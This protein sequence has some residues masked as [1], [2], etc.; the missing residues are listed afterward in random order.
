MNVVAGTQQGN[1]HHTT[2]EEGAMGSLGQSNALGIERPWQTGELRNN[3]VFAGLVALTQ[4]LSETDDL[5]HIL[6]IVTHTAVDLLHVSSGH[7]LLLQKDGF[8]TNR[9]SYHLPGAPVPASAKKLE[10]ISA[11]LIYHRLL[12]RDQPMVISRRSNSLRIAESQIFNLNAHMSLCMVALKVADDPLG[13]LLMFESREGYRSDPFS[14]WNL[15][16]SSMI[17]QQTANAIQRVQMR[18][19]VENYSSEFVEALLRILEARDGETGSHSARTV[20][21]ADFLARKF[22]Y[23]QDELQVLHWAAILHDVGKIAMP[24]EI[25]HKPGPLTA[26]EWKLIRRH[27]GIGADIISSVTGLK[28]VAS[29]VRAH[30]ENYDGTGYPHGLS[31][32]EIPLGARILAVVDSFIAMTEGRPYQSARSKP[33]A[34]EELKRCSGSKYDPTIV[35]EFVDL[36]ARDS[37]PVSI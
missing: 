24:Q 35:Q 2:E 26:D 13:V 1:Y 8:F 28:G 21:L 9:A 19:T 15:H 10:S 12:R 36:I 3:G 32:T 11:Q 17:A 20:K 31:K 16:L 5:Q 7:I 30:H 6:Q 14:E 33:E 27:P 29:I 4:Q 18:R 37:T 34:L 25:L 23:N 22:G